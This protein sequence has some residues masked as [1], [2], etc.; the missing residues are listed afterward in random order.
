MYVDIRYIRGSVRLRFPDFVAVS[1]LKQPK[2]TE[3]Q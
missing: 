2:S 3:A 1:I